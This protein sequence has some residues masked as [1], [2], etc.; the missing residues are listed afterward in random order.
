MSDA[1]AIIMFLAFIGLL[2]Y[3]AIDMFKTDQHNAKVGA[4]RRK[5]EREEFLALPKEERVARSIEA[6]LGGKYGIKVPQIICPHCQVTGQVR[7]KTE[8]SSEMVLSTSH[9]YKPKE[10][11]ITKLHCDNCGTDWRA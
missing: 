10:T 1:L 4:E 6:Q 5:K 2:I 3:L 8:R 7:R 9:T 11:E